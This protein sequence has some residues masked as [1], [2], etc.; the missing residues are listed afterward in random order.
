VIERFVV[1][2]GLSGAGK[3]TAA[4]ALEE[5]GYFTTDNLPPALWW[6]LLEGCAARGLTRVAV[7]TDA[8]TRHFLADL[9]AALER[10]AALVKPELVYLEADDDVL[11]RRYGL[12]RRSHP[13]HEPT[14]LGDLR[15]ERRVLEGVRSRAET[16]IDTS[17]LSAKA[18]VARL[19][20]LY[21][22]DTGFAVTLFSFG[23]KHGAPRDADLV[24]DARSLPNPFYA[25]ELKERSGLEPDVAAHVFSSEGTA[26]YREMREFAAATL[27]AAQRSGRTNY[28]VAVGCTGGFHRSVAVTEALA[29]D[30]STY[31]IQVEH[32]DLERGEGGA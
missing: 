9:D 2:S 30:L 7:V 22:V 29:R 4:H 21:S 15:E 20:G 16:V 31:Q 1:V 10:C 12:T 3:T 28:A 5:F 14:L 18:L 6:S 17:S 24:L 25:P 11:I 19:R 13:L 32:R 27:E 8:R 23:F 26:F